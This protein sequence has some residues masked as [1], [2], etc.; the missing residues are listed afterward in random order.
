MTHSS[1]TFLG[2]EGV[3]SLC[4][5]NYFYCHITT[6]KLVNKNTVN[7][8]LAFKN[9]FLLSNTYRVFEYWIRKLV[10]SPTESRAPKLIILY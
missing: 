4:S 6:A 7:P 5:I 1:F 10:C 8:T 2:L 9:E 3:E